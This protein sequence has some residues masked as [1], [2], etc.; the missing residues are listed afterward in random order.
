MA[1]V[2]DGYV[3]IKRLDPDKGDVTEVVSIKE[4]LIKIEGAELIISE[5]DQKV[6]EKGDAKV[7]IKEGKL[8][9]IRTMPV[10]TGGC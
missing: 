9:N 6:I 3:Q 1:E 5:E 2:P 10:V 7:Q 4:A 8:Q